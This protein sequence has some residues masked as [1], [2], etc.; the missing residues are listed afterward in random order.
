MIAKSW[1]GGCLVGALSIGVGSSVLAQVVPDNTLGAESSVVTPDNI[2]GIESDRID[3]GAIRGANLFH[4]FEQFNIGTGRGAYFTNPA[5]IENIFSRV[6]GANRSEIF[7]RLGVLG[8]GNANLFLINPQGIVFG[9]EASL[10]LQGSFI[11]TTA[12]AVRLGDT[13]LFSATQ[14][15]TS[16][17]LTVS[18]SAIL[19]NT[20][21][22]Q[23]I[24][25]Q[26]RSSGAIGQN[27][28]ADLNPGL[29][30]Q[31]DRT[32]A[33]I[34]GNVLLEGG[35][36]TAAGGRIE[37]GSVAGVGEV[38]L[39]PIGN[40]FV[41]GYDS[42]NDFGNILLSDGAYVDASGEGGGDIQIQGAR[43]EMTQSSNIW[44]NTLGAENGGEVMV[45]VAEVVLSYSF[46]TA[47]VYGTGTGGN[48]IIDTRHLRVRDGAQVSASTFG[49]CKG[50][51]LQITATDSVDVIGTSRRFESG[52]FAKSEGSGDA[53]NLTIDTGRLLVSDGAQVVTS[54][55]SE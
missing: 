23:P 42:I 12:D 55:Y 6:T 37:L 19:F 35:R 14:P 39:T 36:L 38:S 15:E 5:G 50:G 40:R 10:D 25:N 8:N 44:A 34:G 41:L 24:V 11:A 30:V 29:Q 52:L 31:P 49:E 33:L 54:T 1:W 16:N 45:S 22:A 43:L 4:S 13:G 9:S 21:A 51:S 18:P 7:G 46:L 48:L 32:L 53:G 28:S 47:N 26:S 2:G 27:N 3:N 20:I 17:L